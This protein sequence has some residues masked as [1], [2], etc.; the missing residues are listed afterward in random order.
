MY[1]VPA[2]EPRP[3]SAAPLLGG[4]SASLVRDLMVEANTD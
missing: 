4:D 1:R 3:P 2:L